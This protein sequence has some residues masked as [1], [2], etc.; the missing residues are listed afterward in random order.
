MCIPYILYNSRL[1]TKTISEAVLEHIFSEVDVRSIFDNWGETDDASSRGSTPHSSLYHHHSR[2][3]P[4]NLSSLSNHRHDESRPDTVY[5]GKGGQLMLSALFSFSLCLCE[6]FRKSSDF[7][8]FR[9][10]NMICDDKVVGDSRIFLRTHALQRSLLHSLMRYC[11]DIWRW[12]M[13]ATQ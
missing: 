5:S 12:R 1:V 6:V 9:S 13:P 4:S 3:T 7:F 11:R 8:V 10:P 2:R